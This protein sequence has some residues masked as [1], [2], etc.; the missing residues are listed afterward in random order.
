MDLHFEEVTLKDREWI[1]PLLTMSGRKSLDYN[2]TTAF[3]WRNIYNYHIAHMDD[4]FL[5]RADPQ[6]PVYQFPAGQG[7]VEPVILALQADAARAGVTLKL[8]AVLPEHK[9]K[10][11]EAF[12]GKFSFDLDRDG[13]DYVYET[14][15]LATLSGKKLSAKRNH[16]N[17]F[18]ENNP[19][20]QYEPL[21]QDN[22]NDVR[23]M[24]TVWMM[25]AG[26]DPDM[27]LTDEYCAVESAL[28]YYDELGLSGGLLRV[29]GKVIAFSIGDPLNDDTFLVH[30]EKAFSDI[31]GA[32][33]MINQQ[34]IQHTC[35]DYAFV[36]REEDAGV[37]GLR[38]AKLSYR[39]AML[40]EKYIA[41]LKEP[42]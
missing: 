15:S 13:A 30:F 32:Y 39:P 3:V 17:R 4:Y 40:V 1:D 26:C 7:P 24:N 28:R 34:F 41:T 22:I 10:L 35:L 38:Q 5:L 23:Q 33:P 31:Q 36:D 18:L 16:I 20:W 27:A 14:R 9:E 6:N 11:E 12:P 21:S 19:N 25:Q 2:F 29:E 8:N 42:L 37:T